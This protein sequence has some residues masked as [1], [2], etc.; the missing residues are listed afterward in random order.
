MKKHFIF[1]ILLLIFGNGISQNIYYYT[2]S[3]NKVN[4]IADS[5]I[6]YVKVSDRSEYTL[7][8]LQELGRVAELTPLSD[9][10]CCHVKCQNIHAFN[11]ICQNYSN[12]ITSKSVQLMYPKDSSIV[13]ATDVVVASVK[14]RLDIA[15]ILS[16]NKINYV[17]I[18]PISSLSNEFFVKLS[19]N[20]DAIGTA[21][22][23]F[24][25]GDFIYAQPTFVRQNAF[26][27]PLLSY[28]WSLINTGQYCDTSGIDIGI[29]DAWG[30][31]K[32]DTSILFALIDAGCDLYHEDL[33]NNVL[34]GKN[35]VYPS[36]NGMEISPNYHGTPC[37]GIIV[38]E[39]NNIGIVGIAPKCKLLPLVNA[40]YL[41]IVDTA[42][43]LAFTHLL[44]STDVSV[45]SCSWMINPEDEALTNAVERF[46]LN[47][48]HGKG[49]V[50]VFAAGNYDEDEIIYPGEHLPDCI[51]VGAICPDGT[52]KV[53]T[54]CDGDNRWGSN[55][56]QGL[57]VMAP[58]TNIATTMSHGQHSQF[59]Y[60]GDKYVT[61]FWGTSAACPHVVGV[62]ALVLSANPNLSGRK[63]K[64]IIERTCTK[65]RD[66][67]YDYDSIAPHG[68]WDYHMGYGLVNAYQAVLIAQGCKAYPYC[69]MDTIRGNITW[70][71]PITVGETLVIDSLASLTVTDTVAFYSEARIT[72]RPGGKLVVNGG[73][74]TNACD[75]EMW[76]GI[77][78]EGH[79]DIRQLANRQGSVILNNA[80]IENALTAI[81]TRGADEATMWD[82]TGGIVKA[83]NTLFRNNKS[84]AEFFSYENH[85][86][87]GSINDNASYFTRCTFTIDDDNLFADN[88]IYFLHHVV[89]TGVRGVKFNG[90]HFRNESINYAWL[91][92]GSA[93]YAEEAGFLVKRV[94]PSDIVSL[95]PCV[96]EGTA[97]DPVTR[98]TFTGF[99]SA[100]SAADSEGNYDITIDNCDFA[101]NGW[102]V[103]M[104]VCDNARV[105]FC[106]FD[107]NS[108]VSVCGVSLSNC[109]GYIIEDNGF[110]RE[111]YPDNTSPSGIVINYS[112]T[113]E[114]IIRMNEFAKLKNGCLV[115]GTNAGRTTGLQFH[116]N[117]FSC[118]LFDIASSDG[119]IRSVQGSPYVGA[120][121]NFINTQQRSFKLASNTTIT[122]YYNNGTSSH[123]PYNPGT[124]VTTITAPENKCSPSLCGI[125][126]IQRDGESA[127]AQYRAMAEEL[128]A[129]S[130]TIGNR[131]DDPQDAGTAILQMQLSD[132]SAA[133]GDLARTAIRDI[134]SDTVVD[135]TLLKEWYGTIVGTFQETS[136]QQGQ[137]S[138]IPVEA[139]QLAEV[140]NTEGDYAAADALLASLPQRFNPDEPS[141]DEYGNYLNLQRLRENVA[142]NWY[143]QTAAEIAD[144]QQVAE[145]DNGRAARMAKEILCFFH[146][147]CYEDEPLF[148]LE[149]GAIGE[150]GYRGDVS[151]NV[152]TTTA[153][154]LRLHPNPANTTL[155]VESDSPVREITIYDLTGK[156]MMTV[157]V[158]ENDYS[159]QQTIN[160][161][162][163][164][165]GIYLLRA[166]TDN[167]VKTARFVKN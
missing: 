111:D 94:C 110:Y 129:L 152:S 104:A 9:Q 112:G 32:G 5:T 10:I 70:N 103:D 43:I 55:Y 27:N 124:S 132:L 109:T 21:N 102:G 155:T 56:G 130:D 162:S 91:P 25:S 79:K 116:C 53:R 97:T 68:T 117:D 134:L 93:I 98:C 48:R 145:Y 47:G 40:N 138:S 157:N 89:L 125:Q 41:G 36:E 81:S 57:C 85:K 154:G 37:A 82:K 127:L 6:Q 1:Y 73:T 122:Y 90:C 108:S 18:T 126:A 3:G 164:P 52:R 115:V 86:S 67:L 13:W 166:V 24:L 139:Y 71:T 105:S 163:L 148:D 30:L 74:L 33:Q 151:G 80:T 140:Y 59:N 23:L 99:H 143:R 167:G 12:V 46:I 137:Y 38:A 60:I 62:A 17:S 14:P 8:L 16:S 135:M 146:H 69:T 29:S 119:R 96:C 77:I 88:N 100:I 133:M 31:T 26:Q 4:L 28:Q 7:A 45:V 144:L 50:V 19:P 153:D 20:S 150:R 147:I 123:L 87:N 114:N 160:I 75:G 63:V 118:C 149:G 113:A 95:D 44:D 54:S 42:S 72:V 128:R 83:T 121:N 120:D 159:S 66:N 131:P 84:T 107:L 58:G 49:G 2:S 15:E 65:V 76:Q 78:V 141:R 64:E 158:R 106:D 39:D 161:V 101:Q 35:M 34:A 51:I 136:L 142:G 22:K 165:R 156:T 92:R 61:D 11:T